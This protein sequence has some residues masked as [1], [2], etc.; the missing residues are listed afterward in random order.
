MSTCLE[1]DKTTDIKKYYGAAGCYIRRLHMAAVINNAVYKTG[2][3]P[4]LAKKLS[5]SRNPSK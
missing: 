1:T 2:E 3:Q 4:E 5:P